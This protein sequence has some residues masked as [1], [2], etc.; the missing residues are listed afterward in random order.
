LKR[1][2]VAM[3]LDSILSLANSRWVESWSACTCFVNGYPSIL[4][5]FCTV[6][7]GYAEP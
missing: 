7:S 1:N 3:L 4:G 2:T 6:M 5:L